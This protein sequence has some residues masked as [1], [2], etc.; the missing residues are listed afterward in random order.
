[1]SQI[2]QVKEASDIVQIIGERLTLQRAGRNMKANCPFHSE[3]SPSFFVSPDLQVF[4]CFG[5]GERGDIFT[6]L[7]KYEGLTFAEALE[8]LADRAG[9]KLEKFQKSQDDTQREKMLEILELSKEYYHF[10]L[11]K[12]EAGEVGREYLQNRKTTS[13]SIK[14]FQLGYSM[15]SWDGLIKYLVG[16]KK[17]DI[18]DV[19]KAGMVIV[20][21]GGRHYDRFRGRLMFPLKDHRGRVVGFSGRSLDPDAKEAKYIN[22]PE[23]P[24]YHKSKMLFGFSE[25]YHAIREA[26]QVVVVEG[27]FD[28]ISS[29]Q[30]HVHQVVAIKGS[31]LTKEHV[32]LLRR[33]VDTI[34]LSLDADS[35]GIEATKRA[36]QIIQQFDE[37]RLRVL[38]SYLL[39]GKDPDEIAKEDPKKWR[40]A[41]KQSES[42]YQFLI[43]VAFRQYDNL[44]GEGKQQIMNDVGPVLNM[45]H[46]AVERQHYITSLAKRLGVAESVIQ[47]DLTRLKVGRSATVAKPESDAQKAVDPT[48]QIEQLLLAL[49]VQLSETQ[50]GEAARTL[51]KEQFTIPAHQ[52]ILAKLQGVHQFSLSN[53][54]KSL[55][56]EIEA[57]FSALYFSNMR[58]AQTDQKELEETISRFHQLSTQQR[59]KDLTAQLQQLEN[60]EMLTAQEEVEMNTI[61][62]EI[63]ALRGK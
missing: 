18:H 55:E 46:H 1:M 28:V 40:D 23:T 25:N 10:L 22:S 12:H 27:E 6:F 7:E 4:R 5:C 45:I 37:V 9:I 50:V 49:I 58:E 38:P 20:G 29:G 35:A 43:D 31:A 51:R 14:Q 41:V 59:M 32:E 15:N 47:Q 2:Q 48:T 24:L 44:T 39:G 42:V 62:K 53:F 52:Q 3:K 16:K 17:Y 57:A 60:K 36:I 8:M 11:T 56:P 33:T 63:V 34:I 26:K 19:E 30:A 13:E 54:S 21:S 61:L